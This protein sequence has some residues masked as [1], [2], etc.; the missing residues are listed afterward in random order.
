MQDLALPG[1]DK[2][3]IRLDQSRQCTFSKIIGG[4][5]L[6]NRNYVVL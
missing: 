6:G 3:T 4:T 5:L 1:N 2:N